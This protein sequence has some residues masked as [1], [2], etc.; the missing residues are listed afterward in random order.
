MLRSSNFCIHASLIIGAIVVMTVYNISSW[1]AMPKREGGRKRFHAVKNVVTAANTT[2][3]N[4]PPRAIVFPAPPPPLACVLVT[5]KL[6]KIA[7]P[8]RT[9][10]HRNIARMYKA[11]APKGILA[12][13]ATS[14]SS[15]TDSEAMWKVAGNEEIIHDVETNEYGTPFFK[16]LLERLEKRCPVST[17]FVVYAN[18]DIMFDVGLVDTLKTLRGWGK[19]RLLVVGRRKNHELKGHLETDAIDTVESELFIDVA[20]DYF[21]LS[22][23]LCHEWSTLPSYVIGRRAYDNALVDW[24]FHHAN[25]VDATGSIT[26]L[27]Q[28]TRDGNYA[29]HEN[30]NYDDKEFNVRLPNAEYDHGSMGHAHF[31]TVQEGPGAIS[32]IERASG[33]VVWPEPVAPP[34]KQEEPDSIVF[35]DADEREVAFASLP[36]PLFVM[37]GNDGFRE[38][39]LN[40][41]CNMASFDGV[42]RHTLVL[43]TSRRTFKFL[44]GSTRT[45]ATF[46]LVSSAENLEASYDYDTRNYVSLMLLRGKALVSLLNRGK[47]IVWLEPDAYYSRNL[48]LQPQI[49]ETVSDL[50][51]FQDH[52]NY[53]GCFIRF[54]DTPAAKAFYGQII[55]MMARDASQNDQTLLN[56]LVRSNPN[57]NYTVFDPCLFQSGAFVAESTKGRYEN[58]CVGV[59]PVVRQHNWMIGAGTKIQFAK[60]HGR[61]V[62]NEAS[63]QCRPRDLR[64]VVMTMNR[65]HSLARLLRSLSA[66]IYRPDYPMVDLQVSVDRH[67]DLDSATM[68]LLHAFQ[69]DHGFYEIN[70]WD[71]NVGIYG[72][73]V[74]SWPS[75]RYPAWLYRAVVLLEDDL[76][77]SP[78][79]AKWFIEAHETYKS[80]QIG[81]V[82]GMRAGLVAKSGVQKSM[83]DLVPKGVTA[84]AYKL[85]AT[86]SMSPTHAMWT[87]FRAWVKDKRANDRM[88]VPTVDGIVPSEWYR[89]F[90]ANGKEATM[91]EM[92]F[93]RFASDFNYYTVYPWVNEGTLAVVSNWRERGLHFFG[94]ASQDY[95]LMSTWQPSLLMQTPLPMVEW[96]LSFYVCLTGYL[97]GQFSNQLLTIAAANQYAKDKGKF[98]RLQSIETLL[99]NR[100]FL[101]R[102]WDSL[103]EPN[104][105][106]YFVIGDN[107]ESCSETRTYEDV[108]TNEFLAKRTSPG[109]FTVPEL[110]LSIRNQAV[111]VQASVHGRSMDG[112]CAQYDTLCVRHDMDVPNLCKYSQAY[113]RNT[114]HINTSIEITLF[115][116]GQNPEDDA[117]YEIKDEHW[118]PVQVWSMV[119]S[120][121]HIG[122]SKSSMDYM[123][124]LWKR[125]FGMQGT[126]EPIACYRI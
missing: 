78:H 6:P 26:A 110:A 80:S 15:P 18:A 12:Y 62:L 35:L 55:E 27:H 125:Q 21:I 115:T 79:F 96:G 24:A 30:L 31:A 122:N 14:Q 29:G 94:D 58:T 92:W 68:E 120:P 105:I 23:G 1:R 123:I 45:D 101:T 99:E 28:T 108:Y 16:G 53:C 3:F 66:A 119:L 98:L 11:L 10:A 95:P 32:V 41:L 56:F 9:I 113:I 81:A 4:P 36:S 65:A 33:T 86:W 85:I 107:L 76:E 103:F 102:N 112:Q 118:F 84:F 89:E 50:V 52:D 109:W 25:L 39:M 73:W 22:R 48:L 42:L 67:G 43:V 59:R 49:T 8:M 20:Q 121:K 61:W 100:Q 77:V 64:I 124:A 97:Y 38:M 106:P 57:L 63:D 114:F 60:N 19:E 111:S 54:A 47:E 72:Q 126:M 117:T 51:F 37:F 34:Q 17:P 69:W 88:F 7:D 44:T 93:V 46:G 90:L 74:D 2:S 75:E 5:F 104:A 91:W 87:Q 82:T 71:T 116:D 40:F 13:L 83:S 70:V